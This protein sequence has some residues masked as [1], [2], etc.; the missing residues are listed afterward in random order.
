MLENPQLISPKIEYLLALD[1]KKNLLIEN[2]QKE[3]AEAEIV[4]KE[5]IE[6]A[7]QEILKAFSKN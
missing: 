5:R 1:N 3:K 6:E 4:S 2:K 7:F